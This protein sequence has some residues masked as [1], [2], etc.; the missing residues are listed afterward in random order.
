MLP[1]SA[2]AEIDTDEKLK[3]ACLGWSVDRNLIAIIQSKNME[4]TGALEEN[5]FPPTAR[6]LAEAMTKNL[7]SMNK[8]IS[9]SQNES[10]NV[11]EA[12][13]N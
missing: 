9:G 5:E 13:C 3:I 4:M 11:W 12:V 8:H 7:L 10:R 1:G 6:P 2:I